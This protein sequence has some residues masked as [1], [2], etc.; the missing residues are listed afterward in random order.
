DGVTFTTASDNPDDFGSAPTRTVTWVLNDG[1]ASNNLSSPRTTTVSISAS[2]DAPTLAGV[3]SS[4][5]FGGATVTLAPSV[6][7]Q[8]P[9]NLG[10]S[11][12]TVSI[13]GGTFAGDGDVLAADTSGTNIFATYNTTT[14]PLTLQGS[15]TL[16]HSQRVL[17]RAPSSPPAADPTNGGSNLTRTLSWVANDGTLTSAAQTETLT[18]QNTPA[19]NPPAHASFTENGASVTL[20]PALVVT[21]PNSG[22]LISATVA[23]TGG[24]F[25]GDGDVLAAN[26]AGTSIT[27]SYNASTET[28]V[29]SGSDTLAHY[30]Q[31]LDS[32][33]FTTPNDNP[34]DF[35][36]DPTRTVTW[37]VVDDTGT[38]NATG[39]AT[40]TIDITAVNDA[41][42]VVADASV[43]FTEG[44]TTT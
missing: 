9:D 12:A 27:A 2:D 14:E 39:S 22:N 4:V 42:S 24:T 15:D 10:L 41:P 25:A 19:I 13:T 35:G 21:D 33:T 3:P 28:L 8:D 44:A 16:A 17:A 34:T 7:V 1:S 43:S 38:T 11:S 40:S 18:V 37:T 23:L 26:T 36:S 31:V 32:V 20:A 29:L 30:Q 5:T 6:T